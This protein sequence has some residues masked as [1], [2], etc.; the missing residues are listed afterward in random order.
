[1]IERSTLMTPP[2]TGVCRN[3]GLLMREVM[4]SCMNP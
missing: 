2:G 3:A 1:M 4:I